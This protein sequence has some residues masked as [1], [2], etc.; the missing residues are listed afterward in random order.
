MTLKLGQK[1]VYSVL[2]GSIETSPRLD[3]RMFKYDRV[4]ATDPPR[5]E[6]AGPMPADSNCAAYIGTAEKH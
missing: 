2:Y 1:D 4:K 3:G 6:R 5:S